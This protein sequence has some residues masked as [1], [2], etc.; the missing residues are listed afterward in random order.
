[1]P[2]NVYFERGGTEP[3]KRLYEDLTEESIKMYGHDVYYLPRTLVN[4]DLILGEDVSSKF[5]QSY[6]AEMYFETT[7]GFAGEQE[8]IN[9]FGLE[10]R[11]DTTFVI[12]KR[13]WTQLVDDKATLIVD[14]RPNEGD[15]IYFPLMKSFFEI[16]FVEDQEP[17]FQLNNL[18]VYKLRVTRFEYSSEPISTG[19][20]EI[21]AK[22]DARTLDQLAHQVSLE[23]ET[24]SILLENDTADGEVNYMILETYKI[25]TQEP[26]A[27]NITFDSEAGYT[28]SVLTDDIIDF[29]ERNPFGEIDE[30]IGY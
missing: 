16:Q 2:T 21:D 7:E 6:M 20:T 4:R 28:T 3:E 8:I 11:E 5:T 9:K 22:A 24:G 1:M 27:D 19:I 29:T 18:P 10:I 25:E 13:R 30:Q 23:A 15:L 17:F 12:S 14:G 26:F